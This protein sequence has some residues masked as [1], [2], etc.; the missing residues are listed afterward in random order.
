MKI[1]GELFV[2]Y[3]IRNFESSIKRVGEQIQALLT[4]TTRQN[5]SDTFGNREGPD[6]IVHASPGSESDDQFNRLTTTLP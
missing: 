3:Q 6:E 1:E 2:T 4:F 5:K